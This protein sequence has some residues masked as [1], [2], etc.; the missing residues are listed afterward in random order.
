MLQLDMLGRWDAGSKVFKETFS[1]RDCGRAQKWR[2]GSDRAASF[3]VGETRGCPGDC[4]FVYALC[5]AI[6]HIGLQQSPSEKGRAEGCFDRADG[7]STICR[8]VVRS[9]AEGSRSESQ[10]ARVSM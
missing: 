9:N 6:S 3:V 7:E 1:W 2:I 4:G 10:E 8:T 5:R